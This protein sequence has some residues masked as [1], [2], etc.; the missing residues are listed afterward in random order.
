[1]GI[2]KSMDRN[3]R[4]LNENV[5]DF[6]FFLR[7]KYSLFH[8]SNVFFRDI[9]YGIISYLEGKGT[10]LG[11]GDAEQLAKRFIG[12]LEQSS[13]L[14]PIKNGSWMLNYPEF[15]KPPVK[16]AASPKPAAAT[17]RPTA[18]GAVSQ[19]AGSTSSDSRATGL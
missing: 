15:R 1:M 12:G 2:K 18:T 5:K 14:K 8:L 17:S 11:Y 13:I 9:H 10:K 3:V 7:S 4:L 19:T 16:P 6:L